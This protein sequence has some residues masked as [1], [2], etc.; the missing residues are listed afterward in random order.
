MRFGSGAQDFLA[1]RGAGVKPSMYPY[2]VEPRISTD[3][4]IAIYR[5][6]FGALV[7]DPLDKGC[8]V[9]GAMPV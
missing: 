3:I 5:E 2:P 9:L 8:G 6:I 4:F 7:F 1:R